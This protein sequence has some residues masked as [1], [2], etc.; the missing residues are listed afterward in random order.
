MVVS[1]EVN[2]TTRRAMNRISLKRNRPEDCR[3]ENCELDDRP[4]LGEGFENS[5]IA[6]H[7]V[8]EGFL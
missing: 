1:S 8:I 5:G 4:L 2:P 6:R 7:H 3:Q